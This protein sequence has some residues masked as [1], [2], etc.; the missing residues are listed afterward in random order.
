MSPEEG[1]GERGAAE[2]VLGV[3]RAPR[4]LDSK[5][6][7]VATIHGVVWAGWTRGRGAR[8]RR[9]RRLR[10]CSVVGSTGRPRRPGG[11]LSKGSV[12]PNQVLT[13]SQEAFALCGVFTS[14]WR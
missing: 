7:S 4:S 5:T 13:P 14:V 1:R 3:R 2:L 9:E 8:P 11:V 6:G 10:V 12:G